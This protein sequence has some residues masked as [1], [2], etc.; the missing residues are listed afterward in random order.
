MHLALLDLAT[1]CSLYLVTGYD[2]SDFLYLP[3]SYKKVTF[4]RPLTAKVY[5][6]IR[7]YQNNTVQREIATFDFTLFDAQGQVLAEVDQFS[8]RRMAAAA[9]TAVSTNLA[10]SVTTPVDVTEPGTADG[11]SSAEGIRALDRVLNSSLLPNIIVAPGT[12]AE[13]PTD[14][15]AASPAKQKSTT[16]DSVEAVLAGWWEELL[17]VEKVGLDDDFF[18]LGGHS[19]I[20]V[21]LFSKIKKTF[22][23]DLGLS[24]LFEARTV[25]KLAP[26]IQQS[27]D[28]TTRK[29]ST[30]PAV[31]AIRDQGSRLPLFVI[32]GLGGEVIA[33]DTLARS[34][35]ADQPVFAL[36]PQGLDGRKPFLT[37]VEDMAAYYLR[38]IRKVQARGPYC[39]AGYS[40]GGYI[41]FE[42]AQ[43]LHGA[44][45]TV[46]LLGFLD[47]IEWQ[48]LQRV[49]RPE[50]FRERWTQRLK[51]FRG[52]RWNYVSQAV[53][54]N[55]TKMLYRFF[56]KFGREVPQ[57]FSTLEDINRFAMSLYR[58]A[59]YPGRL[60]IFRSLSR[61]AAFENDEF[62]GWERFAA[63]G[64]EVLD[65]TGRHIEMLNE[66]NVRLLA[67]KLRECLD[68]VQSPAEHQGANASSAT[69]T[70]PQELKV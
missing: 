33:F 34:L 17:G 70:E 51:R 20:A 40:F 4:Y 14:S 68:R 59:I 1:G 36:Q 52:D 30:A 28:G 35:G 18:D 39:M 22:Q 19:L 32:S 38:E 8:L 47:T 16:D 23:A 50:N 15:K 67:A 11:I 24:T 3:L 44:G 41:A 64:I 58:P 62:L 65:V 31:V 53:A 6:H 69:M 26:L 25:R 49:G 61:E 56:H 21:R 5:S 45:E 12:L 43:Q 57:Q 46:A 55:T 29:E 66:P 2:E 10:R 27:S 48:Y 63:G 9:A 7:C 54:L 37:R 13:K 60:T 42:I